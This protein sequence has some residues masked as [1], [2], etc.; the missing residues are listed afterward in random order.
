MLGIDRAIALTIANRAWG[1]LA[2]P[3]TLFFIATFLA[4]IEQGFYYAFTSVL[5]LQVF[6][7]LG[8]GF[9]VMQTAS[10][11]MANLHI[12]DTEVVGDADSR[13]RLG[14]LLAEVLSWYTV[15]CVAFI[16]LVW[17]A[18]GWFLARTPS[19]QLV[20]W[21]EAWAFVV[22]IFGLSILANAAYS[23]L[24][25]MG[26]VSDVAAARLIQSVIGMLCLWLMLGLG[27][28]LM[29]LVVLHTINLILATVWII[30]RHGRLLHQ[31]FIQRAAS[32]SIDW[33]HEIWPFQ[34]RIAGSWMAGYFG[35]QA[36]TLILFA[37][38][39]PVEAGRFGF[40]LTAISAIASG[41]TAWVTTKSPRF[42][43]LV[44][45]GRYAEFDLLYGQ[46][47]RG[48]LTVGILG[49][50]ILLTCVALLASFHVSI[51]NRFVP[52][53]GLIAMTAAMLANVKISADATYLRA[54][55][56]EPFLVLSL[57]IGVLQVLAA[58]VLAIHG[59]I[60]RVVFA[61]AA[62]NIGIGFLWA[63][64]LFIRLRRDYITV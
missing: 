33:R 22:P 52:L 53:M 57:V 48:A 28:K 6:F 32:G 26:F 17:I 51:S 41:A 3:A 14:R 54:F 39:G 37:R 34:W 44:A 25:G 15:A 4:P 7:E 35:T 45:Q 31:L 62:I 20:E 1:T 9:V 13:G 30:W 42:G 18:G 12:E 43:G 10:H 8:L 40:S 16:I 58:W 11:L 2:G 61:Y 21:K 55:R 46:A 50:S 47:L 49:A 64:V 56:R 29:A 63:R 60:M 24:E 5:G 36:I 19:S 38:L 27:F 59:G 23:F